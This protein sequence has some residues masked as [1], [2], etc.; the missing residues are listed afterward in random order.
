MNGA[1]RRAVVALTAFAVTRIHAQDVQVLT[2]R[3]RRAEDV[4]PM[5][6]PYL[7]PA[8]KLSGRGDRLFLS[9]TLQNL[10]QIRQLLEKIDRPPRWLT[11]SVRQDRPVP[12]ATTAEAPNGAV[13]LDSRDAAAPPAAGAAH[14][15]RTLPREQVLRVL[16]DARAP[17][18]IETAVPMVFRHFALGAR[19]IEEVRGT[20]AYDAIVRFVVRPRVTGG[21]VT[22]ELEPLDS[23]ILADSGMQGRLATTASGRVGDWIAVGDAD[24]RDDAAANATSNQLRAQ[25]RP[26]TDQRGVWLKVEL[27]PEPAR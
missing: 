21:A 8:A 23:S 11:L 3:H 2:L 14:T 20:I 24:G 1:R 27:E 22:L 16:E 25:T 7:D 6:R 26:T 15:T 19:G 13:T 5:L 12:A 17:V 9:T 4:L 10:A 18:R